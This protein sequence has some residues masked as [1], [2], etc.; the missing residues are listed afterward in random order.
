[1]GLVLVFWDLELKINPWYIFLR[2]GVEIATHPMK[3]G[4]S[5]LSYNGRLRMWNLES[6]ADLDETTW[7]KLHM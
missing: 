6:Y 7:M 3:N 2:E 1:M 4:L 5:F